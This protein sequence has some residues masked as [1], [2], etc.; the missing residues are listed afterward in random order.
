M[1][2]PNSFLTHLLTKYFSFL[3]LEF[4][5]IKTATT[6]LLRYQTKTQILLGSFNSNKSNS[7]FSVYLFWDRKFQPYKCCNVCRYRSENRN[8]GVAECLW[9][10]Q[11]IGTMGLR[12][13]CRNRTENRNDVVAECG[14]AG[15]V[16]IQ[17]KFCIRVFWIRLILEY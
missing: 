1:F 7:T 6:F 10:G 16:R 12:N 9:L 3:A 11:K 2:V 15:R 13:V 14:S 17:T 8:D 4:E 5:L